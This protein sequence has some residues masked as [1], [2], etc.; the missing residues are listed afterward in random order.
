MNPLNRF[1]SF[2]LAG[3]LAAFL[4]ACSEDP[5]PDYCADL[6]PTGNALG[7]V[8]EDWTLMDADGNPHTLHE[9]CGKVIYLKMGARW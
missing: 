2:L 7:E 6:V 1:F 5:A 8:A 9:E 4:F 3:L